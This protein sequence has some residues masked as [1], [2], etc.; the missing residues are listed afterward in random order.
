M[1]D[2]QFDVR[3]V[4]SLIRQGTT[5]REEYQAHLDTLKDSADE[6]DKV[7]SHFSNPYEARHANDPER[8]PPVE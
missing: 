4:K 8:S 5:T 6:A 3:V 7:D 1:E 2:L